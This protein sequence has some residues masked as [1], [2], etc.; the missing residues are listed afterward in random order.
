MS[1]QQPREQAVAARTIHSKENVDMQA[2][3]QQCEKCRDVCVT[4]MTH[5]LERGGRHAEASHIKAF[6]DCI[7]FCATCA[8]FMLRG[9]LAHRR[10]CEICAEVCDACAVSCEGFP[11]DKVLNECAKECRRCAESCRKMARAPHH[12]QALGV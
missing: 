11:D 3:V 4:T 12:A 7:E 2:A 6:L 9:S 10:V 8:G 5:C 1:R